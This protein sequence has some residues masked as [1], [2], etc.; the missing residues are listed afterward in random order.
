MA[1]A[2]RTDPNPMF[3][4]AS[5][6]TVQLLLF[7]VLA[8]FLMVAD[9]RT[10]ALGDLRQAS[11]GL[12]YPLWRAFEAPFTVAAQLGRWVQGRSAL[13]R[14]LT[15]LRETNAI[16]AAERLAWLATLAENQRLL[17]LIDARA[18]SGYRLSLARLLALDLDPYRHRVML[19]RGARDGVHEGQV[20][21]DTRGVAGQVEEA[22]PH[23]AR[24]LLLTDPAHSLPVTV[25]RTG[26]RGIA[27][28][29]GSRTAL[30]L[31]ELRARAA[32]TGD[33]IVTSGLDGR[34]PRGLPVAIVEAGDDAIRA[35]PLANPEDVDFLLLLEPGSAPPTTFNGP[36]DNASDPGLGREPDA[37]P[38]EGAAM[39]RSPGDPVPQSPPDDP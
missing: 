33:L 29:T 17:A 28:G 15:Q 37:E 19:D 14:E 31:R 9:V 5:G 38:A 11:Q 34:F 13:E 23:S 27:Y 18:D 20:V 36:L 24:V 10:Q 7:G 25:V 39:I 30:D 4:D 26:A 6:A 12:A 21:L 32:E 3:A 2:P 16:Y 22:G 8:I 1:S 35:R